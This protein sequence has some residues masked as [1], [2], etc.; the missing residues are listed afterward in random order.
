MNDEEGSESER[1][2]QQLIS[3]SPAPINLFDA[4]GS[5]I[6]GNDAVLDLLNVDSRQQLIGRSIFAFIDPDDH[7]TAKRELTEVVENKTP[8]GP[9]RMQLQRSDGDTR[10]VHVS[11]AP[12]RYQGRDVGQA[13]IIDITNLNEM[14]AELRSERQFIEDALNALQD[15]F[16]VID[17]AGDMERWNDSLLEVSGYTENEVRRMSVED[18]FIEEHTDRVSE[19]ITKAFA[20]GDNVLE[21]TVR[22]K[23]GTELPFEFRKRRLTD[24]DQ[25]VGVVGIGRDISARIAREQHLRVVDRLLQHNLRNQ[26]NIIHGRAELLQQDRETEQRR[27]AEVIERAAD[28]MLSMFEHHRHIVDLLSAQDGLDAID[29]PAMVDAVVRDCRETYPA[30]TISV[31]RPEGITVTA[32]PVLDRAVQQ[33][34]EN[35]IE[36]NDNEEPKVEVCVEQSD[37][38]A[39]LSVIDNGPPIPEMEYES[40]I[41]ADS[42]TPTSHATGLGLWFVQWVVKRSDGSLWFSEGETDGNVITIELETSRSHWGG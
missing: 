31:D 6:W 25:V 3:A 34:I 42:I 17:V 37:S 26:L 10:Y 28:R 27:H 7:Y 30:A 18:F 39:S 16:Y 1:R 20:E 21:A 38:T 2:Y 32:V 24:G 29:L 35:A 11:T 36:H 4:G 5:I 33:L 14:Q 40:V 15:V 13:V 12:G 22:T 8:T 23:Q 9:T 19:S 41:S